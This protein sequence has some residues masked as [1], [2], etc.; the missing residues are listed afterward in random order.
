M[1][2]KFYVWLFNSLLIIFLVQTAHATRQQPDILIDEG[3]EY[4]LY[5]NPLESL[6]GKEKPRPHFQVFHTANMRGYVATWEIDQGI[7]YLKD[8]KARIDGA[9]VGIERIFPGQYGRIEAIWFTGKLRIPQGKI[10]KYGYGYGDIYEYD[11]LIH[12][13]KGK[14]INREIIKNELEG[15]EP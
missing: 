7:L 8:I 2:I 15:S 1:R 5:S 12:I 10:L 3:R 6:F 14:V 13:Q 9:I 11:L 4:F